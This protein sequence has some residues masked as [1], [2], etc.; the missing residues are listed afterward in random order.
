[1]TEWA[2]LVVR[3]AREFHEPGILPW[4]DE[5]MARFVPKAAANVEAKGGDP[6][7]ENVALELLG[8][9]EANYAD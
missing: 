1:M 2:G 8:V 9:L 5:E 7:A 3:L 4:P 6:I